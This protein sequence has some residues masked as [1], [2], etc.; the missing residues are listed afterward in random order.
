MGMVNRKMKENVGAI[1]RWWLTRSWSSVWP[2]ISLLFPNLPELAPVAV[3]YK[4]IVFTIKIGQV[5]EFFGMYG[6]LCP[7][8]GERPCRPSGLKS[9]DYFP[10]STPLSCR[11]LAGSPLLHGWLVPSNKNSAKSI[12]R[13]SYPLSYLLSQIR[14]HDGKKS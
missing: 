2:I 10:Y 7:C 9:I 5:E 8:C 12:A 11:V 4:K 14:E 13:R 3:P 6:I 1:L